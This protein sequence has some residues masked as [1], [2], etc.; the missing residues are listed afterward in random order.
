MYSTSR[1]PDVH[2]HV[3]TLSQAAVSSAGPS[4]PCLI[5]KQ[6]IALLVR[7]SGGLQ[8]M[9]PD[10]PRVQQA[11]ALSWAL[12]MD[13][14]ALLNSQWK[15]AAASLTCLRLWPQPQHASVCP[16]QASVLPHLPKRQQP[17]CLIS[18]SAAPHGNLSPVGSPSPFSSACATPAAA[19]AGSHDA[20]CSGGAHASLNA[21]SPNSNHSSPDPTPMANLTLRRHNS[22]TASLESRRAARR[23]A[24]AAAAAGDFNAGRQGDSGAENGGLKGA[25]SQRRRTSM[26]RLRQALMSPAVP[27]VALAGAAVGAG[28]FAG[29]DECG[30]VLRSLAVYAAAELAFQA[31]QRWR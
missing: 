5:S 14:T 4:V 6:S 13:V 16:P 23:V 31:W 24:V 18:P 30:R 10:L 27:V 20:Q 9:Q 2:P 22:A 3:C 17:S 21:S 1:Q 28:A 12:G 8:Q 15:A 7:L 19:D 26:Q 25:R 11:S 29:T